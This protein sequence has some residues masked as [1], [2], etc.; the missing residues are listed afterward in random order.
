[1]SNV[2]LPI[3]S[4]C[5]DSAS[6]PKSSRLS[7]LAV[8]LPAPKLT[9]LCFFFSQ[10][11]FGDV[12]N[13]IAGCAPLRATF[14][15]CS[16]SY[17]SLML[18]ARL[19]RQFQGHLLLRVSPRGSC[20]VSIVIMIVVSRLTASAT[21]KTSSRRRVSPRDFFARSHVNALVNSRRATFA[22]CSTS[23]RV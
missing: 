21:S 5:E 7:C 11:G 3:A 14:A 19:L 1:M 17:C 4:C 16:K 18:A 8:R 15:P 9:S 12:S 23:S 13:F 2:T 10:H 20:S 6:C 22:P